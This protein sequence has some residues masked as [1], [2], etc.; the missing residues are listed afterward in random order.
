MDTSLPWWRIDHLPKEM[1]DISNLIARRL[2][3]NPRQSPSIERLSEFFG[4]RERSEDS[5]KTTGSGSIELV[6]IWGWIRIVC[7]VALAIA[8][9][10]SMAVRDAHARS[11]GETSSPRRIVKV[12]GYDFPPYV[13][14]ESGEFRGLTLDLIE[15]MN[16]FQSTYRF[17]FV[18][19]S[20]MR[21]Y[22]DFMDEKFD[23][24][25]FENVDWGWKNKPVDVS[26][27]YAQD[28]EVFVAKSLPGR[29]QAY[30]DDLKGK[31][32]LV[33]LGYHYP[34]AGYNADPEYLLKTFNARTTVSHEANLRSV[35]TGRAD[36]AIVTRSY[37]GKYLRNH[38]ADIPRL[39]ISQKTEQHYHH[40][41]L[42]RKNMKPT[43]DELNAL[44]DQMERAGYVSILL[45][46]YG[47]D[48]L[49]R[50]AGCKPAQNPPVQTS[51]RQ[52]REGT[53]V[54]VGGYHFPP[55]V[56]D[57]SGEFSGLTLDLLQL[58]NAFQS[59]YHFEFVPTTPLTRYKD[60]ADRA[61]DVLFFERQEWGWQG[62][63]VVSS[64][65]FLK[66]CEVY[67]TR[68]DPGRTEAFFESLNGKSL[69]GYLG[70][71][72]PLAKFQ[73]DPALLLQRYN[74]R[75]TASHAENI[76]A[77]LDNRADIAVV[78]KS[79]VTRFLRDHPS[80]IP[81]LLVSRK[82]EQEYW[83]T[84][85]VRAGSKPNAKDIMEILAA[86]E[87]NGYSPL[88]WGKYDVTTISETP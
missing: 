28:C 24:I 21:R 36:L 88:L 73:T 62:R 17:V 26:K 4:N 44:L 16:A 81:R 56:E 70:Y 54:K 38:P 72:Y 8:V 60:F 6:R 32:L 34:F 59:S 14:E 39:M 41:L 52:I 82:N 83:H 31:S 78:T 50:S 69:L 23:V 77:V 35:L 25:L 71:H 46:K 30:F 84:I 55:Y 75:L 74:M 33:Y 43:V 5:D 79:Y 15:M 53:I 64:R 40:T 19:T 20:S 58:M 66:D 51:P 7:V 13:Q 11:E 57:V 86:L 37:L 47:I 42:V 3:E 10:L 80:L 18:P 29:T 12:G 22:T 67:V 49:T 68:T 61:F 48:P 2:E 63:P 27:V 1:S 9:A 76:R 87:E 65:E 45:G 85:L